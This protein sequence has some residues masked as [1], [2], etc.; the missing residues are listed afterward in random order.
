MS[1]FVV[2]IGYDKCGSKVAEA[3]DS[4]AEATGN[5]SLRGWAFELK[6][7]EVI[8]KVLISALDTDFVMTDDGFV[9]HPTRQANYDGQSLK[10]D[11]IED[12]T[13][14]IWC[15]RWDQG[16]FDVAIYC[17]GTLA[18]VQFTFSDI[19]SLKLEYVRQLRDELQHHDHSVRE[20]VHIG[21]NNAGE[22]RWKAATGTGAPKGE[23]DFTV[24]VCALSPLK[25]C[26][27]ARNDGKDCW[28]PEKKL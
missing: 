15:L 28:I 21:I 16:C 10:Q 20:V 25:A 11:V 26:L 7:L 24:Q 6:Q 2:M 12:E 8:K 27:G 1:Q 9:L 14:I 4:A 5:P 17:K 3:V 13:T 22:L 19:H 18:T 23:V